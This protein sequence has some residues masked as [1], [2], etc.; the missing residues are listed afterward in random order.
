MGTFEYKNIGLLFYLSRWDLRD[1]IYCPLFSLSFFLFLWRHNRICYSSIY[2]KSWRMYIFGNMNFSFFFFLVARFNWIVIIESLLCKR[3]AE[4][5]WI[6][7]TCILIVWF[8]LKVFKKK[9]FLSH[10]CFSYFWKL[11]RICQWIWNFL[12]SLA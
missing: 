5:S 3:W 11:K 4:L 8:K 10:F 12:F 2:F 7:W 9:H 6:K 1:E